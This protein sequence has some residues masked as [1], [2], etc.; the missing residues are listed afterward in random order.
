MKELFANIAYILIMIPVKLIGLIP[1][2]CHRCIAFLF[3]RVMYLIPQMGGLVR[4]NLKSAFPEKTE[5]ERNRIAVKSLEHLILTALELLWSRGKTRKIMDELIVSEPYSTESAER[6]RQYPVDGAFFITPH[7]GNWEYAGMYISMGY[8]FPLAT[9]VHRPNN[10]LL[11]KLIN[12]SRLVDGVEIIYAR[13]AALSMAHA[14]RKGKSVGILID[15]NTRI[16]NNGGFVNFFGLPV[17]VSLVAANL[18]R[19]G[20]RIL[21]IGSVVREGKKFKVMMRTLC[22]S[23]YDS[24]LELTQAIMNISEEMIREYPE[25]YLWMY[26]RFQNIPPDASEELKR[27]YPPY[28]KVPSERFFSMAAHHGT[29]K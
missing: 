15:Q 3:S 9:V 6:V 16:R 28:A 21:A 14:L 26:K 17:P 5:K 24:D 22:A 7:H 11:S 13:G 20:N 23:D 29:K 25:Q 19:K 8:G 27:R 4:M 18:A 2:W 1:R 12:S 10:P